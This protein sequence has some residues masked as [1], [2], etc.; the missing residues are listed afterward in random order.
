MTVRPAV[1]GV[2]V[3]VLLAMAGSLPAQPPAFSPAPPPVTP[4]SE[5]L[6]YAAEWRFVRAGE[7][8]VQASPGVQADMKLRTLGIVNSLFKVNNVYRAE[9][10]QGGCVKSTLLEA[11]E[12]KK[13]TETRVTY[14]YEKR[15]A[16]F[17]ERDLLKDAVVTRS[18]IEIPACILDLTGALGATRRANL[19]GQP[20]TVPLSDGKKAIQARVEHLGKE[21]ITT[22]MGTFNAHKL[23]AFLFNGVFF[24]RKGR[25]FIWVS[26]D[27][28][29]LPVRV[30]IQ[31]P[32]YI[33]T[34]TL[35]L[36]KAERK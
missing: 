31:L 13:H 30:R 27:E 25:L 35:D 16:Y 24:R 21:S 36:E 12:G 22:V 9:Y 33:G 3:W 11:H 26:D 14:D 34:V 6:F 4:K 20:F 10:G 32:F 7:V 1:A 28:R 17:M 18:D 15:R 8:E 2:F 19:N 5:T 23:E 29:R